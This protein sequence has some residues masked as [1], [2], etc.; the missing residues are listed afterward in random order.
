MSEKTAENNKMK[1]VHS[2]CFL[3]DVRTESGGCID[4]STG[5]IKSLL[6]KLQ[7]LFFVLYYRSFFLKLGGYA[8]GSFIKYGMAV[9]DNYVSFNI[10]MKILCFVE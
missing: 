1:V 5:C 9:K 6:Q 3:G 4:A 8:F 7:E 10:K 2:F